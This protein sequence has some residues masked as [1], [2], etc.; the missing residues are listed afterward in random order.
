MPKAEINNILF[1][2]KDQLFYLLY[3][4]YFEKK[5]DY[6]LNWDEKHEKRHSSDFKKEYQ[7]KFKGILK[8]PDFEVDVDKYNL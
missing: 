7:A 3:I 5:W 2:I 1:R 4:T 6:F 8:L